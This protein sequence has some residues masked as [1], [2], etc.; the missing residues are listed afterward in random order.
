MKVR[1]NLKL[2]KSLRELSCRSISEV[3]RYLGYKTPTGYWLTEN[4]QRS[5]SISTLYK[6][7][8][9]FKL[10]MEN[11]LIIRGEDEESCVI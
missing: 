10:P 11:L 4:G 2:I 5:M 7:S 9:L 8:L 6:L 3:A 1:V